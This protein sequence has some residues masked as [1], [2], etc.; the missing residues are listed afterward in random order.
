MTKQVV[1]STCMKS[2]ADPPLF[3]ILLTP[4]HLNPFVC[5]ALFF[6]HP[7]AYEC[8]KPVC[9]PSLDISGMTVTK[10]H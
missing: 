1:A 4:S 8:W 9:M 6:Y 3:Y 2:Q 7:E 5:T 10:C